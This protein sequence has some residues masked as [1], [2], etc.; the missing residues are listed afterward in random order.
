MESM[1]TL[2]HLDRDQVLILAHPLR[3]RLLSALRLG[4]PSTATVLAESLDRS[5]G[6]TSYHLRKLADVGLVAEDDDR[7]NA[8]CRR[9]RDR[10]RIG[11]PG[12][13]GH[14]SARCLR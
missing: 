8:R 13:C 12:R 7:G 9:C 11:G 14:R 5:T 1:P 4:G 2:I 6:K 10:A 3:H